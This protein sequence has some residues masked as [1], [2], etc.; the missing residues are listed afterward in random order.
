[1]FLINDFCLKYNKSKEHI[2]HSSFQSI[3]IS[4]TLDFVQFD[5]SCHQMNRSSFIIDNKLIFHVTL[6]MKRTS[7]LCKQYLQQEICP[8]D[9]KLKRFVIELQKKIFFS[10]LQPK[11]CYSKV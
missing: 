5:T 9:R 2:T 8:E 4:Y 11:D 1:M 3:C 6:I 10:F 7:Q